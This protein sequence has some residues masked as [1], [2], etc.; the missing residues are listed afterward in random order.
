MPASPPPAVT[1]EFM[2]CGRHVRTTVNR[3]SLPVVGLAARGRYVNGEEIALSCT[4]NWIAA[5]VWDIESGDRTRLS[6]RIKSWESMV[7]IQLDGDKDTFA[8]LLA[9]RPVP[10]PSEVPLV[11]IWQPMDTAPKDCTWIIALTADG[12]EERVHWA[13]PAGERDYPSQWCKWYKR[14]PFGRHCGFLEVV[15]PF[16]GWQPCRQDP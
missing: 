7:R 16:Q 2:W 10:P 5:N 11:G 4:D 12:D 3:V 8:S 13:D 1:I 9:V 14:H 6:V 15:G